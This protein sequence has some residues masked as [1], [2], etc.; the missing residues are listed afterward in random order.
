MGG[1]IYKFICGAFILSGLF[2]SGSIDNWMPAVLDIHKAQAAAPTVTPT[3]YSACTQQKGAIQQ[4]QFD[5][6]IL[7][8]PFHLRIYTPP[9]FKTSDKVH[10]PVLYMLHGQ[11]FNDDQWDRLEMDET[12]D[13]LI[14]SG[15]IVPLIIVMPQETLYLEDPAVSKYSDA[16][17]EELIPWVDAHYPT[18]A[19]RDHRAI[20]GLSRGAG[21]AMR[22]GLIHP[23]LFGS[24]GLHS[25]A[26]FSGDYYRIPKWR[27]ATPD[28]QLPRIYMD[29]GLL[30][31]V[32]DTSKVIELRL[33][34]YSYPHEWH[35]NMGTHNEYYWSSHVTE[36]LL[37][38]SQG[39]MG[40][41]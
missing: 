32:K 16:V 11:S 9:C 14:S 23:D 22:I 20:G 27:K 13:R 35:L 40:L 21:W 10:Y 2:L 33:S 25:L 31:F 18:E 1:S 26:Q 19:D 6:A 41:P 24:I 37:W 34:E 5:S 7:Q 36:Y 39:W 8:K 38:Y 15:T 30:D 17:L 29:I 12:A 28:D 3:P 4:L